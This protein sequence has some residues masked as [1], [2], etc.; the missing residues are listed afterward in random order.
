M[1]GQFHTNTNTIVQWKEVDV[2]TTGEHISI[3]VFLSTK[4]HEQQWKN[5]FGT[6]KNHSHLTDTLEDTFEKLGIKDKEP[7]KRESIEVD[8]EDDSEELPLLESDDDEEVTGINKEDAPKMEDG[9][10]EGGKRDLFE[11]TMKAAKEFQEGF[12]PIFKKAEEMEKNPWKAEDIE[13]IYNDQIKYQEL[14]ADME[15]I[16]QTG[17]GAFARITEPVFLKHEDTN[18]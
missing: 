3:P 15:R 8:S 17:R 1:N 7:E 2:A 6:S 4:S 5:A 11:G 18:G 9:K 16:R 14:L 13:E 12:Q 10:V